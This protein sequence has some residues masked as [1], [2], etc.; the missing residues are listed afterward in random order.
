MMQLIYL[1]ESLHRLTS[2]K[3]L[4]KKMQDNYRYYAKETHKTYTN[5]LSSKIQVEA[6]ELYTWIKAEYPDL[7]DAIP[8]PFRYELITINLNMSYALYA[9]V[10]IG[11]ASNLDEANAKIQELADAS[12][13]KDDEIQALKR[14]LDS[15]QNEAGKSKSNKMSKHR[16]FNCNG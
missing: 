2:D 7:K 13:D 11:K 16:Q 1:A 6:N 14:Q 8:Q 10:Q 15:A 3:A 9:H 5:K 12:R 4:V